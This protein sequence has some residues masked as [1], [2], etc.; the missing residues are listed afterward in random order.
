MPPFQ[1]FTTKAKE[2]IIKREENNND[3]RTV[4]ALTYD[5]SISFFIKKIP[6]YTAGKKV[7]LSE[8]LNSLSAL[9]KREVTGQAGVDFLA[10]VLTNSS[11]DDAIVITRIIDRDLRCGCSDSI[12]S[13]VW[14]NLA[15]EYP[16]L[17]CSLFSEAKVDKW[18]WKTGVFSELKGDGSY[19]SAVITDD[20]VVLRTRSGTKYPLQEFG[21]VI[22][23]IQK[24]FPS[25]NVLTGELLVY[26]GGKVL[27]REIGNGI[28][29]SV[30]KGGKFDAGDVP[31][32]MVWDIIPLEFYVPKGRYN[33]AYSTRFATLASII[34]KMP[35]G[36]S[37]TLT[38][39][40]I[41]HSMEEA[42]EHYFSIVEQGLEG[43][44]IKKPDG[45]WFDGTSK[46][47]IKLKIEADVDLVI[48]G[49]NEG[50]GKNADTFG[51]IQCQSS[52]GK[53]EVNVSGFTDAKR[54]EIHGIRDKLM[55]T[56]MTVKFNNIMSPSGSGMYSLFLP[57]FAEFRTDKFE[58][59]SLERIIEQFEAVVKAK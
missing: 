59:D 47:Q 21:L 41:V 26:R 29:N 3:L 1:N 15:L 36:A 5:P 52:D 54:K 10:D 33:V 43:T 44:I 50:K 30:A 23:Q 51:S 8:S 22:S 58:A 56:I 25:N 40:K 18:D 49:F 37:V 20:E 28:L 16:Y 12:A 24:F 6:F 14:K 42:Y 53:L 7:P 45:I 2:A 4:F 17:R 57:R 39:T 38:P 13:R 27:A 48:T 35:E 46:E 11:V 19:L 32:Y 34:N 9:S 31:V 55:G